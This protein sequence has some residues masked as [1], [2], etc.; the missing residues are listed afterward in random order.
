MFHSRRFRLI[1]THNGT[2]VVVVCVNRRSHPAICP[3]SLAGNS[4]GG[5]LVWRNICHHGARGLYHDRGTSSLLID[6]SNV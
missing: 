3:G 2:A 6:D 1:V 4:P 5:K